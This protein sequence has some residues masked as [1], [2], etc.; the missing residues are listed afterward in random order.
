MTL[1]VAAGGLGLMTVSIAIA[2]KKAREAVT[3]SPHLGS[4]STTFQVRFRAPDR[5]GKVGGQERYYVVSATGPSG[6]GNCAS[7]A[8]QYAGAS[9]AHARVRANLMPGAGGWCLGTFRGSVTEQ[10]RPVCPYREVCPLYIVLVRT[11]GRFS[12]TVSAGGDTQPPVFAGL[13]SA[14]T[15]IP[16]PER[17]GETTK[18]HLT[19]KAAHDNVTLAAQILYDVFE[20]ATS[21]GED[22]SQPSW[23]TAPGA[24]TFTTPPVS[25]TGPAYFVVRARDRAGNED[26]NDIERQGVNPC[27]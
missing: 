4:P 26:H 5:T 7:Q 2:A 20:S 1:C 25:A 18:Y 13:R 22:F 6:E 15:C 11:V 10:E 9:R 12:F 19:W 27:L 14:T 23:T 21:G 17:P 16:G 24:T 3:V 8:N